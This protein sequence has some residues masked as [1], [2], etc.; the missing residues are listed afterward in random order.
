M[1]IVDGMVWYFDGFEYVPADMTE[2]EYF[3]QFM[4]E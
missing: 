4:H 2:E 1:I 3:S